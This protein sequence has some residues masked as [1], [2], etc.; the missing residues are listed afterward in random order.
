MLNGFYEWYGP[1]VRDR[2][3]KQTRTPKKIQFTKKWYK[4][5]IHKI[6]WIHFTSM[7]SILS[8]FMI[9]FFHTFREWDIIYSLLYKPF[10]IHL[11]FLTVK[12]FWC[13]INRIHMYVEYICM[14][15][16][17]LW[18]YLFVYS[19]V[20]CCWCSNKCNEFIPN[21]LIESDANVS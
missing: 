2:G 13:V 12:W 1:G 3:A 11:P 10:V 8:T 6:K 19:L 21:K 17:N 16:G 5:Y 4:R 20:L 9:M 7:W 14:Y 15:V 18:S